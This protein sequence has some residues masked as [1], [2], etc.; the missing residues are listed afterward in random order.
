MQAKVTMAHV[1]ATAFIAMIFMAGVGEAATN[2]FYSCHKDLSESFY[3]KSC[4][5]AT[6]AILDG[7][8]ELLSETDDLPADLVRLHF[9]DCFVRGC[10]GSVLIESTPNNLAEMDA[11]PNKNSLEG[12]DVIEKL[13]TAVEEICPG[14]VS[15]A[16]IV[17]L[18][19][20]DALQ[21]I[22][23]LTI[24]TKRK[25][26]S[27]LSALDLTLSGPHQTSR[28]YYPVPLGRRDGVVS[29]SAE[30]SANL[31]SPLMNF[32][33]LVN[34]FG[35][36]GL[37]AKDMVVLSGAHTIGDTHCLKIW[38]RLYNFSSTVKTDPA[39]DPEFAAQLKKRC[40]IDE[41]LSREDVLLDATKGGQRFD[42]LFYKNVLAGKTAFISDSALITDSQGQ[43]LVKTLAANPITPF[44]QEFGAA[45]VKMGQINVLTGPNGVIR[46]VCSKI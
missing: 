4:P 3:D 8:K 19:A 1:L 46:K 36:Q 12:F 38:P 10:D 33:E 11:L 9:H 41:P 44:F 29:I 31:P 14:V 30:A 7:I 42:S 21:L 40:P 43:A 2:L 22:H 20:R 34:N 27:R 26:S 32:T 28:L 13:K 39:L 17:A 24:L 5:R 45:I 37:S 18:A 16:D 6:A 25:T 15:C 23:K 35:A